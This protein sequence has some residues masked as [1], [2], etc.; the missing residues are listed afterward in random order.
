MLEIIK[1]EGVV[2][3]AAGEGKTAPVAPQDIA[4]VAVQVLTNPTPQR[5]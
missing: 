5:S 1:S 2:Y 3:N 4:A